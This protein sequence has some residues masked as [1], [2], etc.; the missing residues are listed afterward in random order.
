M[1]TSRAE[2]RLLLRQD[3]ADR[4]L[5]RL[6]HRMGLVDDHRLSVPNPKRPLSSPLHSRS[7]QRASTKLAVPNTCVVPR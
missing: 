3:N 7:M 2:Y 4:R 5:T 1:F 6:G